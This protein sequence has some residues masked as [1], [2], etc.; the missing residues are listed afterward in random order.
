M[1]TRIAGEKSPKLSNDEIQL[2][3]DGQITH[4]EVRMDNAEDLLHTII[5]VIKSKPD[6]TVKTGQGEPIGSDDMLLGVY[7]STETFHR[8]FQKY[9]PVFW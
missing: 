4:L 8:R 2:I 5:D 6:S 7:E 3:H 9:P 1:A